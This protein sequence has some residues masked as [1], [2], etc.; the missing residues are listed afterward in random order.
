VTIAI[1]AALS[2]VKQ[3]MAIF[4]LAPWPCRQLLDWRTKEL[5]DAA[6][7]LIH[8]FDAVAD[9]PSDCPVRRN[10]GRKLAGGR[11]LTHDPEKWL[12]VFRK[13]MRKQ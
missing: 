9:R 4:G 5:S 12:P 10:C 13:I 1:S 7:Y 3:Q 8:A 11:R 2:T 6:D